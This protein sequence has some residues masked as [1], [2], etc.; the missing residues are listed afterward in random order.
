VIKS[1]IM[2]WAGLVAW[3]GEERGLYRVLVGNP[4]GKRPL[5]RPRLGGRIILGWIFRKWDM[6]VRNGLGWLRIEAGGEQL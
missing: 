4:E 6:G 2:I 5:G 1:R 3:L